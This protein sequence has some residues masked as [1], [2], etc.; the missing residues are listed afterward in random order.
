MSV[1]LDALKKAGH[2]LAP[3]PAELA[4]RHPQFERQQTQPAIGQK[5][6]PRHHLA[7]QPPPSSAALSSHWQQIAQRGA[8]YA[9]ASQLLQQRLDSVQKKIG[10]TQHNIQRHQQYLEQK[11]T[12]SV[13]LIATPAPSSAAIDQLFKHHA[14]R[15]TWRWPENPT[16]LS[17]VCLVGLC[18][19]VGIL[20]QKDLQQLLATASLTTAQQSPTA[21]QSPTAQ[22]SPAAPQTRALEQTQLEQP[23]LVQAQ[24]E[25]AQ[26]EQSPSLAISTPIQTTQ[27][28]VIPETQTIPDSIDDIR[29]PT[30]ADTQKPDDVPIIF[31]EPRIPP[32]MTVRKSRKNL[33]DAEDSP[34]SRATT[35][36]SSTSSMNLMSDKQN[37]LTETQTAWSQHNKPAAAHS[38]KQYLKLIEQQPQSQ[39]SQTLQA[40]FRQLFDN[41]YFELALYLLQADLQQ[42]PLPSVS[43]YH[44]FKLIPELPLETLAPVMLNLSQQHPSNSLLYFG[45]GNLYALH[46]DWH[47]AFAQFMLAIKHDSRNADAF[48]NAAIS[49]EHL[50]KPA[51]AIDAYEQALKLAQ[52]RAFSFPQTIAAERL[53]QLK[54]R[55]NK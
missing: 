14:D 46:Q 50:R 49:A 35:T 48:F 28:A 34:S 13:P 9:Q 31:V 10:R 29:D 25:Q 17:A 6:M 52:Q 7:D 41:G 39:Q 30:F 51:E 55:L 40:S 53:A 11:E 20:W 5:K 2:Q 12:P 3:H 19:L 4:V 18:G 26:L 44:L 22:Q 16:L 27:T 1:L 36:T 8:A 54:Q 45:L 42:G 23:P 15:M 37:L 38:F 21:E 24:L 47:S 33:P 32:P 43:I